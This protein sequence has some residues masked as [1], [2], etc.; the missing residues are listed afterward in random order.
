V[1]QVIAGTQYGHDDRLRFTWTVTVELE[2]VKNT[3]KFKAIWP[4]QGQ[5]TDFFFLCK[6]VASCHSKKPLSSTV[7]P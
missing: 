2:L 4:M 7:V 5:Q 6:F 3:P 1:G